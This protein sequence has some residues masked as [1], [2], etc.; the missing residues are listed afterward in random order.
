[1][2][3]TRSGKRGPVLIEDMHEKLYR[4]E[5]ELH[6]Y[7]L[8]TGDPKEKALCETAADIIAG[9]KTAFIR[10]DRRSAKPWR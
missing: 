1:V 2:A 7:A 3:R 10:F 5:N 6:W 8:D 9:L 4:I